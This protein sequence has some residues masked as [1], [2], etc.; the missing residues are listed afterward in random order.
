MAMQRQYN[1]LK[2]AYRLFKTNMTYPQFE[3]RV[4]ALGN[5]K[6]NFIR[7]VFLFQQALKCKKCNPN[8]AHFLIASSADALQLVGN[9][10]SHKNFNQ[11]FIQYCPA[12]LRAPPIERF[13]STT[14]PIVRT[15]ASFQEALDYIYE[16]LRCL[17][18][19]E[20]IERLS[21]P[22]RGVTMVGDSLFDKFNNNYYAVDRLAIL[23]WLV[24]ITKES[25][26]AMI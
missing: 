14:P 16:K 8:M 15:Q 17:Y 12:H 6:W 3:A 2:K 5:R 26:V 1:P 11:L 19:H 9:R 21:K 13:V 25:L 24:E 23:D 20:G 18:V 22:P 7:A 10:K 4:N